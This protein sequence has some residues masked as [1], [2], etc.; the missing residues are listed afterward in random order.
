MVKDQ[1]RRHDA[2]EEHAHVSKHRILKEIQL[3][4]REWSPVNLGDALLN[5]TTVVIRLLL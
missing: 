4:V 2:Q 3:R 1:R 5:I